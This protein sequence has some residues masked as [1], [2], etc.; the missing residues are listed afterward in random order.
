MGGIFI[1]N[2][3]LEETICFMSLVA[4]SLTLCKGD[5][6]TKVNKYLFEFSFNGMIGRICCYKITTHII[7]FK[8]PFRKLHLIFSC[9]GRI[10]TK[11]I[12][13][14]LHVQRVDNFNINRTETVLIGRGKKNVVG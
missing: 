13:G 14:F 10:E 4:G 6:N 5:G 12:I 9:T 8:N 1:N 2:V 7:L 11:E 3:G